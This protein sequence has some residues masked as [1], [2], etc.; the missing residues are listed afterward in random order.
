MATLPSPTNCRQTPDSH[1]IFDCTGGRRRSFREKL[2][3]APHPSITMLKPLQPHRIEH[4]VHGARWLGA[5]GLAHD[6]RRHAS[7]RHIVRYRLHHH[8]TRGDARTMANLDI[9]EDLC[10]RAD[11]DAMADFGMAILVLL[12]GAAERHTM[13]DRHIILD[14]RGL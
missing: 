14:H 5:A 3:A 6:L 4:L 7:N 1:V 12:A 11:H 13:E 8:G 9:A 2:L 10:T